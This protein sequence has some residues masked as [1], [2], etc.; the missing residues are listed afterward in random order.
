[1]TLYSTE[2]QLVKGAIRPASVE[3]FSIGE[4]LRPTLELAALPSLKHAA[5][6]LAKMRTAGHDGNRAPSADLGA[7]K[8]LSCDYFGL[9]AELALYLAMERHGLH[10]TAYVLVGERAP[11]GPDFL[12][13][14][15]RFN[16]KC[17]PPGKQFLSVN[18]RQRLDPHHAA[19]FVLPVVFATPDA[20]KVFAPIP[21]E[22]IAFWELRQGHSAYRSLPVAALRPLCGLRQ[23]EEMAN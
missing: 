19:D 17:C 8:N 16:I 10:P 3:S 9:L 12:L 21:A 14:G 4:T 22:S 5:R 2:H 23:L 20:L 15:V 13:N 11:V 1:M 7:D 6:I 18:E